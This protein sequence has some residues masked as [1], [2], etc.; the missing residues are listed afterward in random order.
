MNDT[1]TPNGEALVAI[2]ASFGILLLLGLVAVVVISHFIAKAA[3]RKERH[4]LSFFVLSILLS[5]LITGLVVAALPFTA[6]DP[7]HPKNKK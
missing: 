1:L 6:S 4:Y 2:I 7:N 5:P 3:Q